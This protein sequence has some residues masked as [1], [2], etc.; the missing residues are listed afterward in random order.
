MGDTWPSRSLLGRL[1]EG[2]RRLVLT[3]GTPITYPANHQ[4]IGEGDHDSFA[5]LV[6]DGAVKVLAT[7][8]SGDTGLLT[9]KA[10]GDLVGE[11][12]ALDGKPRSASVVTCAPVDGRRIPPEDLTRFLTRHDEVLV[13]LVRIGNEHLRWAN[14][15][16]RE[17]SLPAAARVA[18]V[19]LHLVQ[20]H[21]LHTPRGWALGYP[22][23]KIELASIAGMKPRTAEKAFSE[24]RTAGVVETSPRRG[25]LIPDLRHLHD[26]AEASMPSGRL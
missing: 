25:V 9:V 24:L 6:L 2:T 20:L 17:M 18:R 15:L 8:T 1:T 26:F 19:L 11:M 16:R 10:R 21:G 22:L 23:T 4:V 12:A 7:D 5:V 14:D 13:E 3:L